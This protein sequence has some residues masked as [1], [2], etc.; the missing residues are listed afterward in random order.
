MK[1]KLPIFLSAGI[2]FWF[3]IFFTTSALSKNDPS[4][5]DLDMN[6]IPVVSVLYGTDRAEIPNE[7]NPAYN[8]K[9]DPQVHYGVSEVALDLRYRRKTGDMI[10]WLSFHKKNGSPFID[11]NNKSL[12]RYDFDRLLRSDISGNTFVFIHGY[13]TSFHNG[14][15]LAA[16][17]AYDLQLKGT[18]IL[19]SWPSIG[20]VTSFDQ[21]VKTVEDPET[22]R[23]ALV[24]LKDILNRSSHHKVHLVAHSLGTRLLC[25]TLAQLPLEDARK[26]SSVVLIAAEIETAQFKKLFEGKGGLREKYVE[27]GCPFLLYASTEDQALSTAL[28][29]SGKDRLGQAGDRL[30]VLKG[31]TTLDASLILEDCGICHNL[32]YQDGIINYMYLSLNQGLP[33][34][35]ILL[36]PRAKEGLDYYEL[37]DGVHSLHRAMD[38]N[39]AVAEQL[40]TLTDS[41]QLG[42]FTEN[43]L[44][45]W[46]GIN[47]GF[48]PSELE[49]RYDLLTG[50]WRPYLEVGFDYFGQRDQHSSATASSL[51]YGLGLE[52]I[53][54]AG[55]GI[56][57]GVDAEKE[58]WHGGNPADDP[59]MNDLMNNADFPWHQIR[60]QVT[61][62][63]DFKI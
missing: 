20:S 34:Q 30:T 1:N 12:T 37:F 51:K 4:P 40:S 13:N 14:A 10:T 53:G 47:R 7:P 2:I 8:G 29:L 50:N 62:Y 33:P 35:Q 21:D 45:I 49:L 24:F 41:F 19:Y 36:T 55:W 26:V 54:D 5:Q 44:Q 28:A 63:F 11:I 3:V 18:P 48:L 15:I 6:A 31:L 32:F 27:K 25:E 38:Y 16:K 9:K 46:I 39:W 23:H 43:P 52:Y 17:I 42:L 57:V 61:R 60:V 56:G 22:T 59:N 58:M